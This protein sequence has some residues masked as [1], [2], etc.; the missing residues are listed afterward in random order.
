MPLSRSSLFADLDV[1]VHLDVPLGPLTWFGVGGRADVL[2]KPRSIDALATLV[3]R[4]HRQGE[5]VHIL[6]SGANLLVADSGVNGVVVQLDAPFFKTATFEN[7]AGDPVLRAMAGAD[8]AKTLN[9]TVRRGFEGLTHLAGIPASIG[10]AIRMNAGGRFGS[11]GDHV[12][13]VLCLTKQGETVAYTA[14]QL[15]F[16]YRHTNIPDPIIL[17]A[18][19]NLTPADPIELRERVKEIFN[20]KKSTQPL[21]DHSAGC[22]FKNPIDPVTE[23][24]VSAGK[25]IDEAGLK[26]HRV[27]GAVVSHQHANFIVCEPGARADEVIELL[28]QIRARVYEV[29]GIELQTEIAIWRRGESES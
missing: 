13:S 28:E 1:E 20:F 24:R 12:R 2:I 15:S 26:G 11:T 4:A 22:T 21:A 16:E 23:Q 27:G 17:G 18:T 3:R 9:E 8:L 14:D 29:H 10:G 6:G 5:P 7:E 25:L 19:F